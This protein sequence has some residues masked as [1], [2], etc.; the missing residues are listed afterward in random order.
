MEQMF[1][2]I[3][4]GGSVIVGGGTEKLVRLGT[5]KLA[6]T[7]RLSKATGTLDEG[8][9]VS[10]GG[11]KVEPPSATQAGP[12]PAEVA[13][14]R[15]APGQSLETLENIG[16]VPV[17]E[18]EIQRQIIAEIEQELAA[19]LKGMELNLALKPSSPLRKPDSVAKFELCKAKTGKADHVSLGLNKEALSEPSFFNP[20]P[21]KETPGWE[22]MSSAQ[23]KA[24]TKEHAKAKAAWDDWHSD[25]PSDPDIAK[26][27]KAT[28]YPGHELT[29][30][31]SF[32]LSHGR[33]GKALFEHVELDDGSFVI[34][35]KYYETDGITFLD[36][37][38]ARPMGPDLDAVAITDKTNRRRI[39]DRQLETKVVRLYRKK[40]AE[41]VRS[42]E[43]FH[44]AEHGLT[45][46]MDDV[47]AG[48]RGTSGS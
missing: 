20:R 4:T 7:V 5:A 12:S 37:P 46:I 6:G 17:R 13:A 3:E 10:K 24:L 44:G 23:Q 27:K 29:E 26:L 39:A 34:R 47:A 38:T 1:P 48:P 9:K 15:A 16:G 2:W 18:A 28:S 42:G 33:T 35:A 25:T 45:L 32:D 43:R 11:S 22:Q 21:L 41:R 14:A 36:S 8:G 31:V 30:P 40:I 19:E